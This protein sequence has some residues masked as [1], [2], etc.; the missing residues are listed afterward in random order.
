[1]SNDEKSKKLNQ[2]F[3]NVFS[4]KTLSATWEK[5]GMEV[6][7]NKIIIYKDN[8]QKRQIYIKF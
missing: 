2:K 5:D 8:F 3:K 4:P 7:K 1:M 6:S